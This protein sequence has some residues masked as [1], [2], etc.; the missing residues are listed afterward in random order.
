[1]ALM[2]EMDLTDLLPGLAAV[3]PMRVG[4][5]ILDFPTSR[6]KNLDTPKVRNG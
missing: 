3:P 1:M 4:K 5:K 2:E 6:V